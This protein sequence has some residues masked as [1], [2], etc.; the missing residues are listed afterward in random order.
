MEMLI[1]LG[2]G[3]AAGWLAGFLLKGGGFG[4]IG[5]M[6]IG[7][8]GAFIGAY[9]LTLLGVSAWKGL[10]GQIG[11]ATFGACVLIALIRLIKAA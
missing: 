1:F 11:M 6:V 2:I 5:D 7:V 10:I 9:L 4:L 3:L 8:L